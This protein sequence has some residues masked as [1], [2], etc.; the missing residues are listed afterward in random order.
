[1]AT[2][3]HYQLPLS[4]EGQADMDHL[5]IY[6]WGSTI[7]IQANSACS[8]EMSQFVLDY[9]RLGVYLYSLFWFFLSLLRFFSYLFYLGLVR[10]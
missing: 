3:L 2:I 6:S 7:C 5:R 8:S 4:L 9:G 1:M 10:Y